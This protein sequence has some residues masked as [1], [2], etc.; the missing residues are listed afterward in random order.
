MVVLLAPANAEIKDY[1]VEYYICLLNTRVEG[2]LQ[3]ILSKKTNQ[4]QTPS[5]LEVDL[6]ASVPN[7]HGEVSRLNS[8][9]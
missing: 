6:S 1:E 7:L 8:F 2:C 5:T 4:S 9:L 3:R